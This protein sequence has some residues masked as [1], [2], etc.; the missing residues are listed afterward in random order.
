MLGVRSAWAEWPV[1][2]GFGTPKVS[3]RVFSV[4]YADLQQKPETTEWRAWLLI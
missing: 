3:V 4:N 1:G 2:A